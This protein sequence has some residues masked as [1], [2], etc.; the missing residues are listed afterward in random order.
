M[1]RHGLHY[2]LNVHNIYREN[3]ICRMV[4]KAP[5]MQVALV[6]LLSWRE[7]SRKWS[8]DCHAVNYLTYFRVIGTSARH[9]RAR[10]HWRQLL[11]LLFNAVALVIISRTSVDHW[12]SQTA[13]PS[14]NKKLP[15]ISPVDVGLHVMNVET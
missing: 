6:V 13:H 4:W 10:W 3:Y 9:I 8:L 11:P 15:Y 5:V 7:K 12:I 2:L 14:W 1:Q